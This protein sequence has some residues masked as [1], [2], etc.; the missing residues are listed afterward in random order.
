MPTNPRH[1]Q[2]QGLAFANNGSAD[3]APVCEPEDPHPIRTAEAPSGIGPTDP[4]DEERFP[5][6]N[7]GG[8]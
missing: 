8:D 1:S 6:L 2:G 5:G 3:P 7:G 4:S